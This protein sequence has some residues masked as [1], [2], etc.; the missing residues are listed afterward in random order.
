[1]RTRY[2]SEHMETKKALASRLHRTCRG[3]QHSLSTPNSSHNLL[4]R[5]YPDQLG[6]SS[7]TP[8][9]HT[10]GLTSHALQVRAS[11]ACAGSLPKY[12]RCG[13]H[14]AQ[15]EEY[16]FPY[17]RNDYPPSILSPDVPHRRGTRLPHF[18]QA[19][20]TMIAL[21]RESVGAAVA[22]ARV[23][24]P[25]SHGVGHGCGGSRPMSSASAL[26]VGHPRI[27]AVRF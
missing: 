17:T 7:Q 1:M 16:G 20:S 2:C 21:P 6:E 5:G 18:S 3:F 4:N 25:I 14:Q 13:A 9:S 10:H 15:V 19:P 27:V 11:Q 23:P 26:E 22:A 12:T 24:W 8:H